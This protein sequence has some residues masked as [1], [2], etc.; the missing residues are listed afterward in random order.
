MIPDKINALG[1]VISVVHDR[2]IENSGECSVRDWEVILNTS[3]CEQ[4]KLR[5]LWHEL[6]HFG[7]DDVATQLGLSEAHE[8]LIVDVLSRFISDILINNK[9]IKWEVDTH[10]KKV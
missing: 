7:L 6:L 1:G 10:E 4:Q 9:D 5:V 8:D 3:L 2:H